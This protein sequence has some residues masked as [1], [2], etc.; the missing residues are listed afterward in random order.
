MLFDD[1]PCSLGE[2]P[3]WHPERGELF[4]F[5]INKH[6]M[7]AHRAGQTFTWAF[8]HYVSAAGWVDRDTLLIASDAALF[9]F[10]L[11][12]GARDEIVALEADNPVTRSNDGR[13]DPQGGF[14][15][16]T[17]GCK[18][19]KG[20]GAYYRYYRGELRQLF[21]DWTIPNATCFSPDGTTA[22]IADTPEGKIWQLRLDE[23]GWPQGEPELWRDMP[24]DS[25]RPDGAVCD[26]AGNL[27]I[28]HY[29]HSKVTCHAPD[30]TELKS[31]PVP[32]RETT[33]PA[34]GG[35]ELNR[36]YVTTA[37]QQTE[38][39]TPD[40][41]CTYLLEPEATGQAEHRVIL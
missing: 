12:T 7:H 8:E 25:Y 24:L 23:H 2:G 19:E 35:P 38:K 30:G 9:T 20:A 27:W 18:K 41:G 28:A 14:W 1:T 6:H 13:A 5:D 10:N 11:L 15:I 16:G 37:A 36:L 4:W 31:L 32:G 22:W 21:P 34:F 29:G 17:M 26:A 3:L 33:C 40:D 39:V